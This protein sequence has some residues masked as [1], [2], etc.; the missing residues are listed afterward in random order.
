M[1]EMDFAAQYILRA[2]NAETTSARVG[3]EHAVDSRG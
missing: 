3:S 1:L 2:P